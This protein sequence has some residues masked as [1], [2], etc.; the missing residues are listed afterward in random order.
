MVRRFNLGALALL[1]APKEQGGAIMLS[2]RT[3]IG[4]LACA[5]AMS[6]T[7]IALAKQSHHRSGHALLGARIKQNGKHHLEKAGKVDVSANVSNSKVTA[8]TANDP[9]KGNLS[10]GKFK[11]NKKMAAAS[12]S[13]DLAGGPGQ[14]LAQA[15]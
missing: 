2:R 9:T 6:A 3:A 14:Q 15:D 1:C 10:I 11:S 5:T 13:L 8:L 12:P 4:V 7:E